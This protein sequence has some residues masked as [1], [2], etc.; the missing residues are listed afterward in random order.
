MSGALPV[1]N[2]KVSDELMN[3]EK[4]FSEWKDSILDDETGILYK[5]DATVLLDEALSESSSGQTDL[6][7][8]SDNMVKLTYQGFAQVIKSDTRGDLHNI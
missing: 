3:Q 8:E 2:V 7:S 6:A 1:L 4:A 5:E